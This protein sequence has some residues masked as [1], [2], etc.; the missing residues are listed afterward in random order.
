VRLSPDPSSAPTSSSSPSPASPVG[1]PSA[2]DLKAAI[3]R[4]ADA[5]RE[6]TGVLA[7]GQGLTLQQYNVL[8]ILRGSHPHP[9][10]TLEIGERMIESTPGI[11]RLMDR[12]EEKGLVGRERCREDRR[13]VH[14]SITQA[15]LV[16]LSELD[17]PVASADLGSMEGMS[18]DEIRALIEL[19]ERVRANP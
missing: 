4:T 8:R 6:R 7:A 2:Q 12:L 16:L 15:G 14:C 18:A 1:S 17:E 3:L 13:M 19:L 11:T 5:L 10:P 9:L